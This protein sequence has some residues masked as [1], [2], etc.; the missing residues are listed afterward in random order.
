MWQGLTCFYDFI[1]FMQKEDTSFLGFT[2]WAK[3]WYD[4]TIW[5]YSV[6]FRDAIQNIRTTGEKV[7]I[8]E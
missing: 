1:Q 8:E 3:K 4:T 5:E 6:F 7:R 2:V